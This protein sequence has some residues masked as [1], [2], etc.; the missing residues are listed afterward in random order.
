MEIEINGTATAVHVDPAMPLLWVLRDI[1]GLTGTK[2]G[3]GVGDCGACIV[4]VDGAALPS[5]VLPMSAMAGRRISTIE[6]LAAP[7]TDPGMRRV[8]EALRDAWIEE[9]VTQCGYC[10]PGMLMAALALLLDDPTPDDDA[11]AGRIGV[12]C[13]CGTYQRVGDAIHGAAHRLADTRDRAVDEAV[14][15]QP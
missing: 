10:Q 13:R 5:C 8:L 15:K 11:I 2:F 4:V 6:M 14:K 1:L 7:R 9:Q 3:C 12:L